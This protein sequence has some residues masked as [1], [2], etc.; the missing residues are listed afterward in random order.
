MNP[1]E[2]T[3]FVLS[4]QA[5]QLKIL[6]R[7]ASHGDYGVK[8]MQLD[9]AARGMADDVGEVNGCIKKYIEYGQPLD[10]VNLLEE[11]GDVLWRIGQAAAAIGKTLQ[12]VI[13]ANVRKLNKRYKG[14]LTEAEALES[15]RNREA[16]KKAILDEARE[17][18]DRMP[19]KS[20]SFRSGD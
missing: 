5:D 11:L 8:A 20:Q 4:K 13:D 7:L 10:E 6:H 16:E 9:N 19:V 2:Y 12:D 15:N 1:T 14:A 17:L 3:E 18:Y